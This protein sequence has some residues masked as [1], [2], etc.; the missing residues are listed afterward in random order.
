VLLAPVGRTEI[1]E[2]ERLDTRRLAAAVGPGAE[3]MTSLDSIVHRVR[4]GAKAGD[5]I[6]ILS[7]GAF[8][9]MHARI[10][11]ALASREPPVV[12]GAP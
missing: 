5:T 7:N 1:P 6:A 12:K 3:A 10:L 11:E 2:A 4:E 9:G 8:G